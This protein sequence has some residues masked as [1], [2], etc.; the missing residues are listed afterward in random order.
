MVI[1]DDIVK[2]QLV[3]AAAGKLVPQKGGVALDISV[4][5]LFGDQVGGDALNLIGR[6]AVKGALGDG[7]GHPGRNAPDKAGVH[8]GEPR[9]VLQQPVPAFLKNGGFGGVFHPLN[10]GVHLGGLDALEVIAHRHI[11][12]KTVGVPQLKLPGQ[13]MAGKPR[14]DILLKRLGHR[15]LGG[16][17]AVIALVPRRDAGL[18]HTFGQLLAVHNL[19]RFQLKEPCARRIGRHNILGQLGVGAGG[20]TVGALDLFVKNGERRAVLVADQPGYAKNRA[21]VFV[22]RQN[23]VHQLAKGHGTHDITHC[24]F[25]RLF[26]KSGGSVRSRAFCSAPSSRR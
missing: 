2:S 20:R 24:H 5:V 16:P 7:V 10:V 26:S 21:L 12:H 1:K 13:N 15:E 11:E 17:F 22:F 9:R 25:L 18:V 23:P 8:P 3:Q 4:Q 6:A 14:L 19:D